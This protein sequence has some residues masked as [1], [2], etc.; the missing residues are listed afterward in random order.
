MKRSKIFLS[1][2]TC[3]LGIAAFAA[4]KVSHFGGVNS[5]CTVGHTKKTATNLPCIT[6]GTGH[7]TVKCKAGTATLFTCTSFSKTLV[8]TAS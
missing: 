3:L 5:G 4:T 7:G 2:T 8:H 6:R 1:V